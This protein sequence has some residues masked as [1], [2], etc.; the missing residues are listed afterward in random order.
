MKVDKLLT[1]F[2][3]FI[4]S[5]QHNCTVNWGAS[6]HTDNIV[7]LC[8]G[9][10]WSLPVSADGF[11]ISFSFLDRHMPFIKGNRAASMSVLCLC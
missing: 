7:L 11:V 8:N 5:E 3:Y 2:G 10:G 4:A 6:R 9:F 1:G